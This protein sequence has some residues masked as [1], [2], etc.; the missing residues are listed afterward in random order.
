[1]FFRNSD[2]FVGIGNETPSQRLDV[3]GNISL[4]GNI[5]VESPTNATLQN[6]WTTYDSSFGTP[7]FSKDKQGRVLLSGLA[8]HTPVNGGVIFTLPAGYRPEK[9]MF[10]VA[11]SDHPNGFSKVLINHSNGEVSVT[12]TGNNI[13]WVS[14]DN[15]TFRGN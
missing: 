14:F 10:F 7:Q 13:T 9:S 3:S 6:G 12:T 1:M 5:I 15:V 8:G 4:S 2:G 11:A